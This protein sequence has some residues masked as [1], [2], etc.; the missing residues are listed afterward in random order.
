MLSLTEIQNYDF[1]YYESAGTT[2]RCKWAAIRDAIGLPYDAI[3]LPY[4]AIGLRL[5]VDLCKISLRNAAISFSRSQPT[6]AS[7]CQHQPVSAPN[8]SSEVARVLRGAAVSPRDNNSSKK[9]PLAKPAQILK[10]A[11]LGAQ[12]LIFIQFPMT[13]GIPFGIVFRVLSK[14]AKN[15]F[16]TTV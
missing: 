14:T 2:V 7:I 12:Y 11:L 10:I 4:D 3:G 6:S 9:W 8:T 16:W 15:L 1:P 13:F 5:S